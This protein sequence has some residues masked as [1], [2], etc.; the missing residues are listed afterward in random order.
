MKFKIFLRPALSIVFGFLGAFIG[1][2]GTPPDIFAITGDYFVFVAFVAFAVLGFI[3]P[4]I[5][6]LA[7]KAGIAVL[8]KQISERIQ[9]ASSSRL[10]V[11]RISLRRR[12]KNIKWENP[13]ILDTSALIDGR[14][15]DVARTGFLYGTFLVI[16]SVISELHRLADSADD[17]KRTRGR[18]GLDS[19]VELQKHKKLKVVVLNNEPKADKVDD[20]LL[21]QAKKVKGKLVTVD[22]NLNKVGKVKGV[23]ILNINE[24][25]SAVKTPVLPSEQLS[26]KVSSLGKEQGQGVGYL[27]DGTMVVV[28]DGA[29]LKGRK[30]K[31][32]VHR[33]LQ[34]A[35]GQMIFGKPV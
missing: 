34:T 33:V 32:S 17:G 3:L 31:V 6:E 8:A 25:V 9:S 23:G 4:D 27:D 21:A 30:V 13:M 29:K 16:P 20:K 18:R 22:F 24:L 1:R 19:L 26:I 15:A 11:P 10:S 12:Q 28:E 7:G 2:S 35:A 14:I 5:V